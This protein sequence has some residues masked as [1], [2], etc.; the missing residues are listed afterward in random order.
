MLFRHQRPGL[1]GQPFMMMKFRTMTDARNADGTFKSDQEWLT[2]FG[3]WLRASSLDELPEL[4]NVAAMGRFIQEPELARLMGQHGRE[5]VENKYDV[6]KVNAVM[7][8]EMV[9]N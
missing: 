1:R 2:T 6:H 3:R 7:L 4:L 8:R 5:M 9:I